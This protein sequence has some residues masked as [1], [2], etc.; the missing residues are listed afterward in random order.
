MA[1]KLSLII[2]TS[3]LLLHS[4]IAWRNDL[5]D[6]QDCNF[7]R[8]NAL[9]PTSSIESEGGRTEFFNPDQKQFRCAGVAFLKHTIRQKGLFV[10]SYA[11]SVLMVFVEQGKGIL[12]LLLPGCSETFQL[13]DDGDLHM[14][15]Q[16]FKKGDLL[17]IPAGVSHW[18]YNNG[19]QEIQAVVMFDTT[20]RANQLDNIPQ[21]F[22]ILGNSQGQQEQG[23]QEQPLIQQFQG[24]SVLKGFD[25]RTLADAFRVN[26][27]VAS[28]LK[29]QKIKQGHIIIV[30]KELEVI[31]PQKEQQE[32]QSQQGRG[33]GN[34]LEET[35]CSM[36]IRENLDK[37]ERADFFNP[38]AG[39]LISLNSHHL[40]I[41]GDVRLSAERGFLRKNAMVAP[42]WV[43][44]AHTIIYPTDGE[45]R[46]QIVNNQGKQVFDGRLKKGQMV[47]VPQNFAVMI[48]AGSQG[49]R[50]VS[51]KTNDNAMMT[52]IAG[53]G[54]VFRGLPVSVLANILQISEEQAS[55]LKYSNAE[56]ILFAPQQQSRVEDLVRMLI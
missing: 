20:N 47:L 13:P 30:D 6:Q 3:L 54:S 39:H 34:G 36:R 9:E 33:Q 1:P 23:Q 52:P 50:W 2:F 25:V 8:L 48:Q 14:R 10:P 18:I 51:F 5:Q 15:V 26:Q 17:I 27:E 31:I 42:H 24:D 38:Q 35:T 4:C 55:N 49:F 46:I 29:G 21:R 19:D 41:L 44:N 56:T 11:N 7:E 28:K 53:R 40:P 32:E 22:F 45:A 12:G 37:I 43:L 16:R